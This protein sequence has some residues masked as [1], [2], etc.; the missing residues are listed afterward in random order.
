[1][2]LRASIEAY[3]QDG[4]FWTVNFVYVGIDG[5]LIEG[6]LEEGDILIRRLGRKRFVYCQGC[7]QK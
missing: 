2:T 3:S 4:E 5:E 1:M 7:P 6:V